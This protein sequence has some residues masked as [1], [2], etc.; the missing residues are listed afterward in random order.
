MSFPTLNKILIKIQARGKKPEYFVLFSDT[1]SHPTPQKMTI[2][3]EQVL[4][5]L[6][7]I[8]DSDF[9]YFFDLGIRVGNGILLKN[10]FSFTALNRCSSFLNLRE[11][12]KKK[13]EIF[14]GF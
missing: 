3:P 10:T 12:I 8:R 9:S 2:F 4:F 7:D 5:V 13:V 1:E 6:C 14:Q 11:V